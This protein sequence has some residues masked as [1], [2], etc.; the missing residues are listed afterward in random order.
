MILNTEDKK[1]TRKKGEE[2]DLRME[3]IGRCTSIFRTHLPVADHDDRS[4][5]R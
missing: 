2:L 5:H 3:V 4:I 1:N